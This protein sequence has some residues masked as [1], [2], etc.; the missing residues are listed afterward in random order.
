M[1]KVFCVGL[2]RTGTKSIGD[3]LHLMGYRDRREFWWPLGDTDRRNI[4][5]LHDIKTWGC[6]KNVI[7]HE[8]TKF[9]AFSDTPWHFVFPWLYEWYPDAHF[10][11][12]LRRTPQDYAESQ[13][14]HSRNHSE[15]KIPPI[16]HFKEQYKYHNDR[17]RSFFKDKRLLEVCIEDGPW[18]PL[19]EFLGVPAPDMPFPHLNK[20]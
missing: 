18:G 4:Y 6:V 9:D 13:V 12:T 5:I 14:R 11:L 16:K 1:R 3:A 2:W 15:K 19:S 17:V 8:T 20:G 7:K 10:I